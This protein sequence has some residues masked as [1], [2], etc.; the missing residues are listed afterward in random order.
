MAIETSS[1][2]VILTLSAVI[3]RQCGLCTFF[4]RSAHRD[5][6]LICFP[7]VIAMVNMARGPPIVLGSKCVQ[8]LNA[9]P[10]NALC[11]KG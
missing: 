11:Y 4:N 5:E 6:R 7:P 3:P 10:G 9:H 2:R 1:Q 8:K